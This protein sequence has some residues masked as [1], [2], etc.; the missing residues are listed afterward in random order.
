MSHSVDVDRRRFLGAALAAFGVT[1]GVGHN[2]PQEAP[3]AFADAVIDVDR[4]PRR[5]Q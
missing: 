2:L 1:G 5:M 4:R 3:R